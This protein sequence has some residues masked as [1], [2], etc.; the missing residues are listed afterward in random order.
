MYVMN[1]GFRRAAGRGRMR[2]AHTRYFP[3][4]FNALYDLACTDTGRGLVHQVFPRG[5]DGGYSINDYR[6]CMAII[7]GGIDG[8]LGYID[9]TRSASSSDASL[10]KCCDVICRAGDEIAR[11]VNSTQM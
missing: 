7:A 8:I 11:I 3:A 5:R 1:E 6:S 9:A 10:R 4:P 2:E